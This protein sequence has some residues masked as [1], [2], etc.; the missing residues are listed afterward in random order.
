MSL[1]L[2]RSTAKTKIRGWAV[3]SILAS[4]SAAVSVTVGL[5]ETGN[6]RWLFFGNKQ[7]KLVCDSIKKQTT[8]HT[9]TTTVFLIPFCSHGLLIWINQTSV[10]LDISCTQLVTFPMRN[11]ADGTQTRIATSGQRKC[12]S[13][14]FCARKKRQNSREALIYFL[15]LN[16]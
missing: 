4:C 3:W 8:T 15:Q 13:L 6:K 2:W 1:L 11:N 12:F 14:I 16:R 7:W 9:V 5:E 10:I